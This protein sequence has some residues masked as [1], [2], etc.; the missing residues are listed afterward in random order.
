MGM[1]AGKY[2]LELVAF[3]VM[4][5]CRTHAPL[6]TAVQALWGTMI[7]YMSFSAQVFSR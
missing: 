4:V 1:C 3:T 5:T 2:G 7:E 6:T